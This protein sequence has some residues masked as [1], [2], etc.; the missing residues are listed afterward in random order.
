MDIYGMIAT[1]ERFGYT[2]KASYTQHEYQDTLQQRYDL[3]M[4]YLN[5]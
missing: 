3:L 2:V 1:F 5:V 4:N